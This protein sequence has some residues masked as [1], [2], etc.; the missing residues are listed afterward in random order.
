MASNKSRASGVTQPASTTPPPQ[1][2]T[3]GGNGST[4]PP[5]VNP[6][7]PANASQTPS[8]QN[9]PVVPGALTALTQMTDDELADLVNTSKGVSMPNHLADVDDPTQKFVYA[10][11]L[12]GLPQVLDSAQFSQF[13]SDNNIPQSDIISRSVNP[14]K[15]TAMGVNFNYTAQNIADMMMYSK[16][17]Y[18]GGKVGGQAYGAGTYFAKTGGAA[19]GYGGFT[20]NAVLNPAT[21]KVISS[22][23]LRTKAAAFAKTHPKFAKAVGGYTTQFKGNNMSIWA[24][25]MG[26]NVINDGTSGY[27]AYYN[28][29]DRTA[30]VYRK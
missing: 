5:P 17:N 14:I 28:V 7:N 27:N 9:T 23:A 19:T 11:G 26:Y 13:M 8:Q 22:T 4:M 15:F 12:N 21:A 20:T 24:L 1:S 3:T 18:I 2:Y 10:A 25:A 16:F 29:I 6:L 30:L